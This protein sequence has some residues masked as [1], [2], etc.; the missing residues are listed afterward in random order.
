MNT[1]APPTQKPAPALLDEELTSAAARARRVRR[2]AAARG[3][4]G[5]TL[6]EILVVLAIIGLIVGAI[7]IAAFSQLK[8]S[9]VATAHNDIATLAQSIEMY[10][11]QKNKCPK[12]TQ[13]L[14]AAGI[15]KKVTKDPWGSDYVIKCPGEHSAADISSAG[16]DREF[17][18]EDDINSWDEGTDKE[19]EDD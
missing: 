15:I 6:I 11:L 19:E 14:K 3:T 7:S 5:M 4:R 9:K 18:T 10:Q 17:D 13:D 16:E 12:T 8:D 1:E 2:I